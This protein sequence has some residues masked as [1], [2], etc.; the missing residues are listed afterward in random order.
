MNRAFIAFIAGV[1]MSISSCSE[2]TFDLPQ[3]PQGASGQSAYSIWLEEVNSGHISWDKNKTAVVDFFMFLKG[4]SGKSAY[5]EWK[6]F[7]STGLVDDPHAPDTKWLAT[8]NSLAD[9]YTFLTGATGAKGQ[10]P[11]IGSDGNWWIGSVNTHIK[12]EAQL[13]SIGANGNWFINGVDTGRPSRGTDGHTP[14]ITIGAN[15]NWL[16][17]GTDTGKPSRGASGHDGHSPSITIGANG[18]IFIDGV[19]TGKPS[20][21]EISIGANGNWLINGVDTGRRAVGQDAIPPVITIGANGHWFV[22]GIDTGKPS[23]GANGENGR[24]PTITIGDNGNIFVDG[25][26]T[27]KKSK[28]EISIGENDNWW[29]DGKDTGH[30]A[31]ATD[32]ARGAD[33]ANGKDGASAYELWRQDLADKCG[34]ATPLRGTDGKPWDCSKNTLAD[35]WKFLQG[36]AGA[37]TPPAP[38]LGESSP[39]TAPQSGT[40]S[41]SEYRIYTTTEERYDGVDYIIEG[42]SYSYESEGHVDLVAARSGGYFLEQIHFIEYDIDDSGKQKMSITSEDRKIIT[43]GITLYTSYI[44]G[45]RWNTNTDISDNNERREELRNPSYNPI[46]KIKITYLNGAV[47]KTTNWID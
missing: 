24:T 2:M 5:E 31:Y 45:G 15:G 7:I 46:V 39:P 42:E 20:M 3:G 10:T 23:R 34:T 41:T 26:D 32:G 28:S 29:I 17:D 40:I 35:F 18:N 27:G 21:A 44:G 19:D 11:H 4:E 6:G 25:T 30:K 13:I 8:R 1:A 22:D 16:I 43:H 14:L 38:S 9:F 47:R 36:Q 37:S 12:A 33:G